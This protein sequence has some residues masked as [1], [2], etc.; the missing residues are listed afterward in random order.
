MVPAALHALCNQCTPYIVRSG[1]EPLSLHDLM[2]VQSGYD[3]VS[4]AAAK[5]AKRQLWKTCATNKVCAG[6]E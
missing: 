2:T 3:G 6:V 5:A 4:C 1:M